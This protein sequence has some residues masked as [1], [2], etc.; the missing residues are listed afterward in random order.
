MTSPNGLSLSA[1]GV[2]IISTPSS[3]NITA[4][5]QISITKGNTENRVSIEGEFHIKGNNVIKNGSSREAYA[6]FPQGGV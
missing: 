4:Q 2:A 1:G 6:P 5:S 3:I